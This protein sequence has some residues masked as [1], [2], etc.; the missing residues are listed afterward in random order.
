MMQNELSSVKDG[1]ISASK[2]NENETLAGGSLDLRY[3]VNDVPSWYLC[4]VLGFQVIN[5]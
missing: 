2:E 4:I 3:K 5:E 1:L